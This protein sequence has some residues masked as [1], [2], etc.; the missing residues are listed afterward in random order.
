MRFIGLLSFIIL[1]ACDIQAQDIIVRI[2]GDTLHVR[3]EKANKSFVYY[4]SA[5][6]KRGE[7]DVISRQEV[8]S[9]LYNFEDP[10]EWLK[11]PKAEQVRG[12]SSWEVLFLYSEFFLPIDYSGPSD[13]SDYYRDLQLGNGFSGGVSF[14]LNERFGLRLSYVRSRFTNQFSG[15]IYGTTGRTGRLEDD[16]LLQYLGLGVVLKLPLEKKRSYFE[17]GGGLGYNLYRNRAKQIESYALTA[18]G[19]GAHFDVAFNISVGGGLFIPIRAAV[20]GF[21]IGNVEGD[22]D[23]NS[24]E[25][26]KLIEEEIRKTNNLTVTRLSLSAGLLFAF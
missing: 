24:T 21:E 19:I 13:F 14:F 2:T 15:Q 7:L 16:I 8:A 22:V 9:I 23:D 12:F 6:T 1:L 4:Q 20:Y 3:V 17:I 18:Q 10:Q 25:I 11:G 5:E 26:G